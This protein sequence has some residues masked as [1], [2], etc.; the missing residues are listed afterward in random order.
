MQ[1]TGSQ[2]IIECLKE[3]GVDTVFGY[4]GGAILNVYDELYKHSSE[5]RHILTTVYAA[6]EDKGYNPIN[7]IVGYILSADPTYITNHNSARTL[8]CKIDRDELLQVLVKSY[9]EL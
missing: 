3:Q 8:I 9:L 7:Q 5:I 6:L 4:P 2:V 1:L